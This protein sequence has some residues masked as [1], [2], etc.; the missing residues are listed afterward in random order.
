[1]TLQLAEHVIVYGELLFRLGLL[2]KRLELL[3][4]L[5]KDSPSIVKGNE[6]TT[7]ELGWPYSFGFGWVLFMC[8][9]D[10]IVQ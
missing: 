2:H 1:M 9:D 4:C 8:A 7:E 6:T 5:P 10:A 3:K